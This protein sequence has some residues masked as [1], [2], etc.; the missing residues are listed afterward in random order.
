MKPLSMNELLTEFD[1]GNTTPDLK[2]TL[3]VLR[4]RSV[5]WMWN[6]HQALSN[7]DLVKKVCL[8]SQPEVRTGSYL[9]RHL[10]DVSFANGI[11]R[12]PV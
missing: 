12:C 3:G 11:Y 1:K 5:R 8:G 10:K 7:K 9:R 4:D 6:A 2:D